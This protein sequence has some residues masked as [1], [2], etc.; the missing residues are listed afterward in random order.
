[1]ISPLNTTPI[2]PSNHLI[3]PTEKIDLNMTPI[4]PTPP[5]RRRRGV[6]VEGVFEV[7]GGRGEVRA[8]GQ[9]QDK[10]QGQDRGK[11]KGLPQRRLACA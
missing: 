2:T 4:L 1:M 3:H 7:E 11:D 6:E 9:G 10:G 8:M 5:M